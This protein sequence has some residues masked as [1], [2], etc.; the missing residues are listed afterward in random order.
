MV[1]SRDVDPLDHGAN[2]LSLPDQLFLA[3]SYIG[4]GLRRSNRAFAVTNVT[5]PGGHTLVMQY[6]TT[7]C[8]RG[9]HVK[10]RSQ[11]SHRH[12]CLSY[13]VSLEPLV[14]S[15]LTVSTIFYI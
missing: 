6:P 10:G 5:F 7:Q 1:L 8:F 12:S 2:V 15:C 4:V 13:K 14:E 3:D 11:S 9:F